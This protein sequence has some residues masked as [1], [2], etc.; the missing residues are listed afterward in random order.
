MVTGVLT[1]VLGAQVLRDVQTFV[2]ALDT[3]FGG[4][5]ERAEHTYQLLAG[6]GHRHSSSSPHPSPTRCAKPHTSWSGWQTSG[7]RS[8]ASSSTGYTAR[9]AARLSAG[10]KPCGRGEPQRLP[11]SAG[12]RGAAA[13]RGP[14]AAPGA[15]AAAS[16]AL[17]ISPSRRTR[18]RGAR[19][20]QR[21]CT[22]S[23]AC[24][25]SGSAS[26]RCEKC[27]VPVPISLAHRPMRRDRYDPQLRPGRCELADRT[28]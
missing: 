17:H 20:A 2:S 28:A 15:R 25:L 21:T 8:L 23:R 22:T 18:H 4:F 3:M 10:A 27:D 7:C 19:P 1:K 12:R 26:P 9:R 11:L 5:R 6:A 14:D 16:R 24:G 13:A